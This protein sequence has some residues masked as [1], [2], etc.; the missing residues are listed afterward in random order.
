MANSTSNSVTIPKT[1]K[2]LRLSY[3]HLKNGIFHQYGCY[4]P[5]CLY[6]FVKKRNPN[7]RID[8]DNFF[9][10]WLA[11]YF[12]ESRKKTKLFE[13]NRDRSRDWEEILKLFCKITNQKWREDQFYT[14]R[15]HFRII[16][17]YD[18]KYNISKI[19]N[20]K[21]TLKNYLKFLTIPLFVE[22]ENYLVSFYKYLGKRPPFPACYLSENQLLAIY[23]ELI[24]AIKI[25]F[26]LE[27]T[28]KEHP[29]KFREISRKFHL[30]KFKLSILLDYLENKKIITW[31]RHD[32]LVSLGGHKNW[33]FNK[34]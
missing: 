5:A 21:D 30:S 18:K 23:K 33:I 22:I 25:I 20:T 2:N 7:S 27:D 32:N 13:F 14:N 17:R 28:Y 16:Y 19:N 11:W 9:L 15:E 31:N 34:K 29:I 4:C 6:Y 8:K 10:Y 12:S 3:E 24:K 1:T 26:F